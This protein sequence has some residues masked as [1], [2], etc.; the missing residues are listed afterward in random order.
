MLLVWI[1]FVGLP[2]T[3]KGYD[4]IWVIIDRLAK[5]AH[6]LLV[7]VKHSTVDYAKL[8]INRILSLLGVPKTIISDR[9]AQ[10]VS[11]F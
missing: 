11:K 1:F 5:I 3:S 9:G 6:F 7:K 4:Y 8:Y 10:F 2:K